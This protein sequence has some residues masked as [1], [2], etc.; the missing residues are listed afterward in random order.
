MSI[1]E[2]MDK[3]EK[4]ENIDEKMKLSVELARAAGVPEER[5]NI[6]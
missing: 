5:I 1:M 2:I 4:A 6:F 3:M